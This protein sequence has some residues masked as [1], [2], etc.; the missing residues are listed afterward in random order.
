MVQI[1]FL[2]HTYIHTHTHTHTRVC[3]YI[4]IYIYTYRHTLNRRNFLK[5]LVHCLC[6]KATF[7]IW[8]PWYINCL[9]TCTNKVV[10]V[11]IQFCFSLSKCWAYKCPVYTSHSYYYSLSPS[12]PL[13]LMVCL[14]SLNKSYSF[15][16]S[17]TPP[18]QVCNLLVL[19][20]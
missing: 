18:T 3:M 17:S 11:H 19:M 2:V 15:N 1:S 6:I 7:H 5:S 10:F 9:L 20:Y 14:D 16:F 4:Y 13:S 12:F 8:S